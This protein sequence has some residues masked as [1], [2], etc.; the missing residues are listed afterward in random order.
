MAIE[1]RTMI[2]RD[3][4]AELEK[5]EA[6]VEIPVQPQERAQ[7]R[8]DYRT[9]GT[10]STEHAPD[11]S[12][13]DE[14]EL[15]AGVIATTLT[16]SG[17]AARFVEEHGHRLH[18]IARWGKWLT[19]GLD[20]FWTIDHNDVRVRQLAK[21]VG[22][23][24]Q[25]EASRIVDDKKA[26]A[27]F[28]WGRSSL[29]AHRIGSMVNLARG[30]D[31]IPLDH[32]AL[33]ANGWVLGVANGVIDL[34]TGTL[35]PARAEDLLSRRSPILYDDT[36]TAP[37]WEQC[38]AE[39]FPDAEVRAYVHR[40][41]GSALVGEQ[42][43][44]IMAIHY[45]G[46]GNGKGTFTRAIQ[47]V[48][49]PHAM[50]AHLSLLVNTKRTE[51]DTVKAQL[52]R[53]RLA[54]A[55]ETQRRVRLDE[56]SVKNLTGGDRI[57]ARR[58]REDPWEFDPT[59]SLW[60]QTNHL[61]E[62]SG[63]DAGIWRRVRVVKWVS[64]F[65]GKDQDP[66]LDA[67]LEAEAP[68][69]LRWL[70]EGCLAWQEH[71]LAEPEAVIRDTLEYRE[72]E[73]TFARFQKE[74]GLQ[75]SPNLEILAGEIQDLLHEWANENGMKSPARDLAGW[76]KDNGATA[77]RK[78]IDLPDGSRKRVRYWSGVGLDDEQHRT[79]QTHAL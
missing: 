54:V 4:Y 1:D 75:F 3:Q 58:M 38:L 57:T 26:K 11:A 16:D 66:D 46:G 59:H 22:A 68:G 60:L 47:H 34:S 74:T 77:A 64:H 55:S 63:R 32:E 49:G 30:I 76:L 24:L 61:P 9:K 43:D 12:A 62:I 36:A 70:V 44:H 52:F 20:G 37:R 72:A 23:G 45:G 65:T 40:L 2:Y 78:R 79:E 41:A 69:I 6:H 31:G 67:K 71:G 15:R 56:A 29:A 53:A 39:W 10:N 48:L 13:P 25:E 7:A 8:P 28:A 42:R 35:R 18:Y 51:H 17:N 33:D 27:V 19:A 73:D 50:V 14:I 21:D 5:T